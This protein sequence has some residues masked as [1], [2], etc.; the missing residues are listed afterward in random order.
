MDTSGSISVASFQLVRE[1]IENITLQMNIG[2]S[3]SRV[4]VILFDGSAR[5]EFN[6]NQYTDKSSLIESVR[7][8]PYSG[9][10]TNIPAALNLLRTTAQNGVLGIRNNSRQI[11]IFLTDGVGGD[12]VPAVAALAA[13][14]IFQVYSVGIDSARL[15]QLN[16]I[17][18]NNS[19]YVYYHAD[20][21]EN[22]LSVI[23]KRIIERL[24]G[25]YYYII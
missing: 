9:G 21:N 25:T 23:A 13:A 8:L 2:P 22:S 10:N 18:L 17:A 19:D 15:D 6:L 4:A 11:A 24:R 20:F 1:F 3:N 7:S 5:L 14:G 16:L 12:V